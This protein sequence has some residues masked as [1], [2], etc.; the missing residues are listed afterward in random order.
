[1][2]A[3]VGLCAEHSSVAKS[4]SALP[5][6]FIRECIQNP[7]P[8]HDEA[9]TMFWHTQFW[10]GVRPASPTMWRKE[11]FSRGSKDST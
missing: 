10:T 6:Q 7:H 3:F 2:E 1:M 11:A 4:S 8:K 9:A 5:R